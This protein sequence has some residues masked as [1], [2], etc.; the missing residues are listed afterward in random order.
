MKSFSFWQRRNQNWT[1]YIYE[2][3]WEH[4]YNGEQIQNANEMP[5]PLAETLEVVRCNLFRWWIL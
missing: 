4:S 2:K 1:D 3:I 5:T